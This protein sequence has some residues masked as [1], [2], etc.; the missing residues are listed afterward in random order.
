MQAPVQEFLA[1]IIDYA[2]LFP[3]AKLPM[4]EAFANYLR[5][6]SGAMSWMLSRFICPARRLEE[7]QVLSRNL[8]EGAPQAAAAEGYRLSTRATA[9]NR[10]CDR[11]RNGQ[12]SRRSLPDR[13][14]TCRGRRPRPGC[15]GAFA[16]PDIGV[17]PRESEADDRDRSTDLGASP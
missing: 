4:E 15:E 5:Y 17:A 10:R 2:G 7:V 13:P 16:G 6:R 11:N 8:P 3:P 12:G 14:R 1:N 9:G